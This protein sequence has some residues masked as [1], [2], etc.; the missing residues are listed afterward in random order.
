MGAGAKP[1][2]SPSIRCVTSFE[3]RARELGFTRIAGVDEVGRGCLFGPVVAA[4]VI[5]DPDKP[6]KYVRDS[7]IVE[8]AERARLARHIRARSIAFAVGAADVYEI[9]QLNIYQASR[10]A[11]RRAVE[12]LP[13]QPDYLLIDALKL[14]LP[15]VQMALIDGDARCRAIAAASILAKEHRDAIIAQWAEIFPQYNLAANKGYS[16]PDHKRA[17]REHGPTLMHRFSFEP[18]RAN[19]TRTHWTGYLTRAAAQGE[20]FSE[21][22]AQLAAVGALA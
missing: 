8:A 6:I 5:L 16:T 2:T 20:L 1:K 19:C 9:D 3:R 21:E 12:A 14:D 18:V 15:I 22:S 13:I 17:L 7:K 4:A 10:L 11:M